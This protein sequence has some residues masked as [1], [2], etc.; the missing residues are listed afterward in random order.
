MN[1]ALRKEEREKAFALIEIATERSWIWMQEYNPVSGK[2]ETRDQPWAN[3][4]R[5]AFIDG[6]LEGFEAKFF[7]SEQ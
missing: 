7:S 6:F 2:V 3:E 1:K 5:R 4:A